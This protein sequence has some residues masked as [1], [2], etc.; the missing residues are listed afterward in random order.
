MVVWG[1]RR[2]VVAAARGWMVVWRQR[3]SVVAAATSRDG[4][5]WRRRRDGGGAATGNGGGIAQQRV[6]VVCLFLKCTTTLSRAANLAYRKHF[7]NQIT[8]YHVPQLTHDKHFAKTAR[9]RLC[10]VFF[11]LCSALGT[12]GKQPVARRPE[13][14][15]RATQSRRRRPPYAT[16]DL[17]LCCPQRHRGW[18]GSVSC[19][20]MW[21]M[22]LF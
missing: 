11:P 4:W 15:M 22:G 7:L 10:R 1:Q 14:S 8:H 16:Q 6:F 18:I 3:R 9:Q 19:C 13:P 20:Q 5:W 2:R 17:G 12:H 21:W